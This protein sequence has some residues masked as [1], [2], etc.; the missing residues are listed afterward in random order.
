LRFVVFALV[1]ACGART[2]LGGH[3]VIEDVD[4]SV[5]AAK[6]AIAKDVIAKDVI[7]VGDASPLCDDF[8]DDPTPR[9]TSD[10]GTACDEGENTTSPPASGCSTVGVAWEWVPDHDMAVSR[11]E[12]WTQGGNQVAFYADEN[13]RPGTRLFL[14]DTGGADFDAPTW[15]GADVTPPIPVNA[16]HRYYLHQILT[17]GNAC[18]WSENGISVREYTV[19]SNNNGWDGPFPGNWMARV[20]GACQ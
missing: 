13:G 14:G 2:D 19:N 1:A 18:S 15:R 8:T 16:C 6:D 7:V 17:H 5:D 20:R 10:L 3:V 4:A 12:L 9:A 11:L